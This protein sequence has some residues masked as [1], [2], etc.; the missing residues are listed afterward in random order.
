LR[1]QSQSPAVG[2]APTPPVSAPSLGRI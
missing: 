1:P 2:D